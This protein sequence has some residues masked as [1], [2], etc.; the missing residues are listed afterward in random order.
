M[1]DNIKRR[2][3]V[4]PWLGPADGWQSAVSVAT[5]REHCHQGKH[6][7]KLSFSTDNITQE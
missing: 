5:E 1:M 2:D 4:W 7:Y 6:H 3:L